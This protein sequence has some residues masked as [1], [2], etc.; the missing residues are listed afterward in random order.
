MAA[1][2]AAA[3]AAA[4]APGISGDAKMSPANGENLQRRDDKRG[5]KEKKKYRNPT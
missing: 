1:P 5:E 3:A 2:A 4:A